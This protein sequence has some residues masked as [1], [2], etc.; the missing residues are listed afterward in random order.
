MSPLPLP[1]GVTAVY[2]LLEL[3]AELPAA[4]VTFTDDVPASKLG[5]MAMIDVGE[6]TKNETAAR[7][8]KLTPDTFEKFVPVMTTVCPPAVDPLEALNDV[9]VG[10]APAGMNVNLS[11]GVTMRMSTVTDWRDSAMP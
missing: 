10:A 8:P 5:E 2:W 11:A 9:T 4:V 6:A 7:P 1:E 3:L